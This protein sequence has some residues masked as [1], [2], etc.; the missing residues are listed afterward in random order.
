MFF[1]Y[2]WLMKKGLMLLQKFNKER[3]SKQI[4][5]EEKPPVAEN[6]AENVT[7]TEVVQTPR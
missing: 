6:K 2:S 1:V 4:G 3:Q 7:T 5:S